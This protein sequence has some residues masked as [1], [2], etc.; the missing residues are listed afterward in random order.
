MKSNS[1]CVSN[2]L[3]KNSEANAVKVSNKTI[4][5]VK[6]MM[7]SSTHIKNIPRYQNKQRNLMPLK[8]NSIEFLGFSPNIR[9]VRRKSSQMLRPATRIN[10]SR[11]IRN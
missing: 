7:I 8:V 3:N 2:K 9:K 11:K 1:V 4:S 6:N 5:K 10:R